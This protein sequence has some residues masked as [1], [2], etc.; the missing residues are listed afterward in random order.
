MPLLVDAGM[1]CHKRTTFLILIHSNPVRPYFSDGTTT[2]GNASQVSDG[3]AAVLM[4]SRSKA[5]A[6]GL[7]TW[8][9]LRSFAAVG[10]P[11]RIMGRVSFVVTA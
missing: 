10:V 6:A 9:V 3:A 2:A 5:E 1:H 8:G 11:P 7:K 4:M